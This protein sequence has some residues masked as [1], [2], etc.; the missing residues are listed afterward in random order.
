MQVVINHSASTSITFL[1]LGC[2][3]QLPEVLSVASQRLRRWL[4]LKA[5]FMLNKAATASV[6]TQMRAWLDCQGL[7]S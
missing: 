7:A 3:G 5:K 2:L 6:I 1:L 4:G